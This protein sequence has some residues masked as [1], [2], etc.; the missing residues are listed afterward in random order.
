MKRNFSLQAFA[1]MLLA[2]LLSG[3]EGYSQSDAGVTTAIEWTNKIHDFGKI[4]K[5]K[6][7]T[8][9]FQFRNPSLVPLI[10]NSVR[11]SCGCTVADYPKEPVQPQKAGTIKVTFN[12]A[13]PGYFQKSV[14]VKTS[15]GEEN[16]ILLI[17]GEVI[18]AV[19]QTPPSES[20]K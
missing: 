12:A 14:V 15:A 7:V 4:P 18:A 20:M 8:A 3:A 2:F 19:E 11:P 16:E 1:V 5:G 17:K 13:S 6:P 9:E 10:I